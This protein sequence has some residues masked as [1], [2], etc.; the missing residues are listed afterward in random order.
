MRRGIRERRRRRGGE[1]W[2][3]ERRGSLHLGEGEE[4]NK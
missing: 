4:Q 2:G 3:R 1:V